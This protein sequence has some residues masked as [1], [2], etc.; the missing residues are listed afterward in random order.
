MTTS[1]HPLLCAAIYLVMISTGVDGL[2]IPFNGFSV[3]DS[4]DYTMKT[5]IK[6]LTFHQHIKQQ[7]YTFRK[8]CA[9]LRVI[10]S[11]NN[12]NIRKNTFSF[13]AVNYR[14]LER[15]KSNLALTCSKQYHRYPDV[16]NLSNHVNGHLMIKKNE[17]FHY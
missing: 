13:F 2:K 15:H 17:Y 9:A 3:F 11:S 12:S 1:C 5:Y 6:D 8:I 10:P 7:Y 16:N 4:P 14:R